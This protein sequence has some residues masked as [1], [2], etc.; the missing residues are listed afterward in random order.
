MTASTGPN[1]RLSDHKANKHGISELATGRLSE[2]VGFGPKRMGILSA[3]ER[4]ELW[5]EAWLATEERIAA[6]RYGEVR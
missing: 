6:L 4:W 2:Q 1:G 5:F 3:S